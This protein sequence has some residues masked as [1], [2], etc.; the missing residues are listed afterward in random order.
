MDQDFRCETSQ[1][2]G[3]N[4]GIYGVSFCKKRS[5]QTDVVLLKRTPSPFLQH[6]KGCI[7]NLELNPA[8]SDGIASFA[9]L[10]AFV[11]PL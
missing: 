4:V 3:V 2:V 10:E 8:Q 1:S 6:P 7:K 11:L 9:E 5:H